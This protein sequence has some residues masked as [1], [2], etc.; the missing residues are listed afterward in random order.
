MKPLF[1]TTLLVW[2][3]SSH[4]VEVQLAGEGIKSTRIQL[5]DGAR[6]EQLVTQ[7]PGAIAGEVY[8]HASRI[9]TPALDAQMQQ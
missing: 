9:S 2:A 1:V 4:A 3:V 8:W 7:L 5:A 6:L